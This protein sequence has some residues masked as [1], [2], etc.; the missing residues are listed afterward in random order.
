[1]SV[2]VL[3]HVGLEGYSPESQLMLVGLPPEIHGSLTS[4]VN[5]IH[6]NGNYRKGKNLFERVE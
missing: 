4:R 2:S 1:V 3:G 5:K 6:V